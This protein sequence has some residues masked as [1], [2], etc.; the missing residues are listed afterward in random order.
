MKK[1]ILAVLAYMVPTFPLGYLWHLTVFADYYKSLD[2]FRENIVVPFGVTSML[3][4]GVIWAIIYERMFAGQPILKGALKF[5][6]VACP[7]AWSFMVLAVSAKHHMASVSG[8][9]LI[10]TAFILVHYIVV[11]PLIAAVYARKS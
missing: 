3:I 2:V 4:Q 9:L 1:R 7:L 6:M 8:F 5:A 10:E 11:S